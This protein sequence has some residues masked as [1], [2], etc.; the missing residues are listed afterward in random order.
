ME[1]EVVM[2]ARLAISLD[3]LMVITNVLYCMEALV[4]QAV[5]T[6]VV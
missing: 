4:V 2:D 6:V 5:V 3:K 1:A